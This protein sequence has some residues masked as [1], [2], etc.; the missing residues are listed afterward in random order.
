MYKNSNYNYI[1][2]N[3]SK[4]LLYNTFRGSLVEVDDECLNDLKQIN[5]TSQYKDAFIEQGFWIDENAFEIDEMKYQSGRSKYQ[6]D[7]LH[8][9]LKLTD[10]CN[11]SCTYCFQSHKPTVLETKNLDII[12]KYILSMVN[13]KVKKVSINLFGGEPLL[14]LS[15]IEE[16]HTFFNE[17]KIEHVFG[18]SSNGYLLTPEIIKFLAKINLNHIQITLDGPENIHNKTRRLINGDGTYHVILNN[19]VFLYQKTEI[20]I[21]LRYN[22]TKQNAPY[23]YELFNE[24]NK[25]KLLD[26]NRITFQINEAIKHDSTPDTP[27]DEQIYFNNRSDY[28][29]EEFRARKYLLYLGV[30]YKG[31]SYTTLSCFFDKQHNYAIDTQLN[32]EYCGGTDRMII[33]KLNENGEIETNH[34]NYKRLARDPFSKE[35]CVSCIFLPLCMGGCALLEYENKDYCMPEKY[36]FDE[37]IKLLANSKQVID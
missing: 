4:N 25:L 11:F 17:H 33:G 34:N 14:H 21:I 18:M 2:A 9:T 5:L 22:L 36:I 16:L 32:L 30:Y 27:D 35:K 19:L 31:F 29:K 24:L 28:I 12:K 20:P 7:T 3:G 1:V 10:D 37:Y 8:L 26:N 15:P 13:N 23:I 6:Q